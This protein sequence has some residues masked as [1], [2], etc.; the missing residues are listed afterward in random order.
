MTW[1]FSGTDPDCLTYTSVAAAAFYAQKYAI[2][3]FR[4][5]KGAGSQVCYPAKL[6][7]DRLMPSF[8]VQAAA[9]VAD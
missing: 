3:A 4:A 6:H 9:W 2:E 8:T 7:L 1:E 5:A